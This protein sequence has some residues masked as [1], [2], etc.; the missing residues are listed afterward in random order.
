M[1]DLSYN[2]LPDIPFSLLARVTDM[3]YLDLS[4]NRLKELPPQF[5]R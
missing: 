2:Q 4:H 5:R 1:L 3:L